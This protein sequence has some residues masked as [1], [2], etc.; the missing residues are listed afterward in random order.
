[1]S[2]T[3]LDPPIKYI[4]PQYQPDWDLARKDRQ[5]AWGKSQREKVTPLVLSV[6]MNPYINFTSLKSFVLQMC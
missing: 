1:M 3:P 4:N 6:Y 5:I 2:T